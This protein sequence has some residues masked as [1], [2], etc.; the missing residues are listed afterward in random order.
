[1]D[2]YAVASGEGKDASYDDV[3]MISEDLMAIV[4]SAASLRSAVRQNVIDDA[5]FG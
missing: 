5:D 3:M 4:A 2:R 1:M